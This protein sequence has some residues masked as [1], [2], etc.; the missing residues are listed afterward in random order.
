MANSSDA[1]TYGLIIE[2]SIKTTFSSCEAST[3]G[4]A[5]FLGLESGT[6]DKFNLGGADY[7]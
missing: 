1:N 6:E 3:F 4:G 5:I 2:G 7:S